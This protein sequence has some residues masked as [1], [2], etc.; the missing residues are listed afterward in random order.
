MELIIHVFVFLEFSFATTQKESILW[1]DKRL[2]VYL[3]LCSTQFQMQIILAFHIISGCTDL[4]FKYINFQKCSY[5]V[6]IYSSK[7]FTS[8][9][10]SFLMWHP[11][12]KLMHSLYREPMMWQYL[13]WVLLLM[14]HQPFAYRKCYSWIIL[15]SSL[16]WMDETDI[17]AEY[18]PSSRFCSPC[19]FFSNWCQR[20][21]L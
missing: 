15:P 10:I 17:A 13:S 3:F 19:S 9:L 1:R 2:I 14:L 7:Q 21:L 16:W 12:H 5:S 4:S 11:C 20:L 18:H 6:Y 8:S